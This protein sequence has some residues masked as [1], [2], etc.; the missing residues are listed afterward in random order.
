MFEFKKGDLVVF[1]THPFIDKHTNIKI[2]AYSDYT[3]PI[4]VIKE[5]KVKSSEN[6]TEKDSVKQLNC[7]YYNSKDGKFTERWYNS[8]L[9]NK[10]FFSVLNH[11][12]L[13]NIDLKKELEDLNKDLSVENYENLIKSY[14]NKKVVLKSV[15][16]ELDKIKVNRTKDNGEL[17]ETNHLEFLPPLMAII[18]FKFSDEKT[19]LCKK[20]SLPFIELKCKWYNSSSKTFSESFFPYEILYSVIETQDLFIENDL[21]SDINESIEENYFFNLLIPKPFKLE[22]DETNK[23]I[24]KTIGHS[25]SISF[26]HYFYQMNY[27]D[28]LTQKKS[29]AVIDTAF[30]KINENAIF[31]R[32]YPNY[33]K[34]YKSKATDCKFK[35]DNYYYIVY[36]DTFKNIT[37]RIIKVTN[38]LVIIKDFKKFKKVYKDLESWDPDENPSF[39]NYDYLEDEKIFI[40]LDGES[41]PNNTLPKTIFEDD[42]IEIMLNTN[43]LLRKGKIRNFKL[44]RISEVR[45]IIDGQAIFED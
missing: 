40:H 41:I 22:E 2:A 6:E 42:N 27:F 15:D 18:G 14:F 26:K 44:N 32:K 45:E 21:L 12:I 31:G 16:I 20:S 3:S 30:N 29:A 1:K 11:K 13:F 7:I 37:R 5:I 28:Y 9:V 10:I 43:C 33:D 25:E 19:K 39:V 24:I 17:V 36:Q 23:N 8:N 35:I 34:G 38:L 4:L